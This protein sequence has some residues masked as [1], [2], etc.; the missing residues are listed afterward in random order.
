M[1][2][3]E[4]LRIFY[5]SIFSN[6][7]IEEIDAEN[8]NTDELTQEENIEE[9]EEENKEKVDTT[10]RTIKSKLYLLE[11]EIAILE[12][13]YWNE[14]RMFMKKIEQIREKCNSNLKESDKLLTFA[15][16]PEND[17]FIKR[18]IS[19]LEDEIKYFIE[20]QVKFDIFSKQLERLIL[21][22]N[23]LYNV[24]IF[25]SKEDE[26]QK[27]ISQVEHALEVETRIVTELKSNKYIL[28]D[29]QLKERIVSLISYVDYE[30]FKISIRNSNKPPEELIRKL[31][32]VS[33]FYGFDYVGYF[34]AFIKDEITDLSE[35]L[36]LIKDDEYRNVFEQ[37]ALKLL[38]EFISSNNDENQIL[39]ITFWNNFLKLESNLL[40]LLK[41]NGLEK[42]KVKIKLINR[43]NI[44]TN[45]SEV[46]EVP[47]VYTYLSLISLF[48]EIHDNKILILIKLIENL[49]N[50]ITYREIYFLLLL[51]D[52]IEIIKSMPNELFK[53]VKKYIE[54]YPY[55]NE[56]IREKKKVVMNLRNKD[57]VIAF[58]LDEYKAEIVATLENLNIDFKIVDNFVFLNSFYFKDLK[59]VF[60]SM[61]FNTQ[62]I[63]I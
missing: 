28:R 50:K 62:N 14:H 18:D 60:S 58:Y 45:E 27:A 47:K 42:E 4:R 1:K 53:D 25:H 8:T 16:T 36:P 12:S 48:S 30:I 46:L 17:P 11:Q 49:S 33:E 6:P 57:Y 29:K 38:T 43:M 61:Q 13:D 26:K 9:I 37:N 34:T 2:L 55:D 20:T 31:V 51:F 22:L 3:T 44:S 41:A 35:L 63:T 10:D 19:M 52:T 15:I 7:N 32:V 24:S 56:S 23:V 21:K 39:N 54:K 40:K 59:N 5:N